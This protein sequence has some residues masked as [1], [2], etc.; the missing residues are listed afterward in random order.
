M[1]ESTNTSHLEKVERG[2]VNMDHY[3]VNFKK[4]RG[5]LN[6][7]NFIT[8]NHV[9][10]SLSLYPDALDKLMGLEDHIAIW[11][12]VSALFFPTIFLQMRTRKRKM[13]M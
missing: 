5:A 10:C 7:L 3:T 1:G 12:S 6:A 4:E 13:E 11:K 8:G 9:F 2:Y